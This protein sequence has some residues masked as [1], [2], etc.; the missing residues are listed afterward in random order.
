MMQR[1]IPFLLALLMT[2]ALSVMPVASP[3]QDD[4]TPPQR[5]DPNTF[6]TGDLIWPKIPSQF[7]P[8]IEQADVTSEIRRQEWEQQRDALLEDLYK[9][10]AL[11]L[12][13]KRV[14][15]ELSLLLHPAVH[16]SGDLPIYSGHVGMIFMED[17]NPWVVE[18]VL[19]KVRTIRYKDWLEE[20]PD[21]DV[22][23]ARLK[24]V[25]APRRA[26]VAAEAL[27]ENGKPYSL[28]NRNLDDD[29]AF[30]C[31]KLIWL[32]AFRALKLALD[33]DPDPNR[34]GWY[35]PKELLA[36]PHLDRLFTPTPGPYL[37]DTQEGERGQL[38]HRPR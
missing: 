14:E 2:A 8:F 34:P 30:Y 31:S 20:R 27:K 5:P 7:I 22:W 15:D 25:S 37:A 18:A 4:Q 26:E 13:R 33:D 24:N 9:E 35:T 3:A 16:S 32:A 12:R 38:T 36:S 28:F 11:S 29:Q 6:Q 19:D 10:P 21:A 1:A 23:H 17:G